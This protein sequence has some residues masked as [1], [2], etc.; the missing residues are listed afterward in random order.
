MEKT[1]ISTILGSIIFLSVIT[2]GWA[3]FQVLRKKTEKAKLPPR[4]DIYWKSIRWH[5]LITSTAIFFSYIN[6]ISIFGEINLNL[7]ICALAFAFLVLNHLC[8]E[9]L[10]WKYASPEHKRKIGHY[11][12]HTAKELFLF[13]HYWIAGIISAVLFSISHIGWGLTAVGS[14]FWVGIGLQFLVFISGGLY[15]SIAVHFIHNLINGIIYGRL[16]KETPE[17]HALSVSE[18][19]IKFSCQE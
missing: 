15:V 7:E 14:T 17:E 4:E 11:C 12:P 18:E 2:W 16:T 6:R 19:L 10:E 9:P 13:F 1:G 3:F 5:F 8:I